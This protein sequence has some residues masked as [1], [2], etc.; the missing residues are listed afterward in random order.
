MARA[1]GI[2]AEL[3][4]EHY[5]LRLAGDRTTRAIGDLARLEERAS[6][7]EARLADVEASVAALRAALALLRDGYDEFRD[8][9]EAR[10]V[11]AV[12]RHLEALGRPPLGP[13]RTES[14]LEEPTVGLA[15]RRLA[16]DSP[17][18]SHGQRHLVSLA[19]RLGAADF[20]SLDGPA[21]PLIVDEPFAHL[22]DRHAIQVWKLLVEISVHRQVV[23]T[24]QEEDLIERLGVEAAV[25]LA[26]D[27]TA[28]AGAE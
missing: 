25:R 19:I 11:A 12:S 8:Q 4:E 28:A 27:A 23:V 17:E 18:L 7:L 1:R 6:E 3:R 24:T 26:G 13:F 16:F 21:A 5:R 2:L 15:R 10:L 22:D 20:L 14:G 9:D